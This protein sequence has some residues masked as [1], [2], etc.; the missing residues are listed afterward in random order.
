M[1]LRTD[2]HQFLRIKGGFLSVS[3]DRQNGKPRIALRHHDV[4]GD[5]V[6]EDIFWGE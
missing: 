6:N 2:E 4:H 5:V 1:S 3:V